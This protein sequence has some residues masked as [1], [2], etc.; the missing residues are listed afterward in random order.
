MGRP[1]SRVFRADLFRAD[2]AFFVI[3]RD[4]GIRRP[5]F[6]FCA[7]QCSAKCLKN[8]YLLLATIRGDPHR[9]QSSLACFAGD[10]AADAFAEMPPQPA[11]CKIVRPTHQIRGH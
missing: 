11:I 4:V 1:K 8:W 10:G 5:K 9:P 6:A 3:G 7:R 2:L